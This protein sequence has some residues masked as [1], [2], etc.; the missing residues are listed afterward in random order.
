MENEKRLNQCLLMYFSNIFFKNISY[1]TDYSAP[2]LPTNQCCFETSYADHT[3]LLRG[4][5]GGQL[6]APAPPC[7]VEASLAPIKNHD[8]VKKFLRPTG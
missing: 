8:L 2:T 1:H 5:G 3:G 7:L 6:G 4:G